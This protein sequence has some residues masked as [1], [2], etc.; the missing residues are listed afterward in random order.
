MLDFLPN[1]WSDKECDSERI[2]IHAQILLRLGLNRDALA[3]FLQRQLWQEAVEFYEEITRLSTDNLEVRTPR[4]DSGGGRVGV[5]SLEWRATL[6][7]PRMD[8]YPT[9]LPNGGLPYPPP[10]GWLPPLPNGGL[11]YPPPPRME[12]Y[13]SPPPISL[14]KCWFSTHRKTHRIDIKCELTHGTCT[15]CQCCDS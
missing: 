8:G 10:N 4:Y 3:I 15:T 9:P 2:K 13:P 5:M 14:R 1:V 12:G 6:P 11:P 7:P